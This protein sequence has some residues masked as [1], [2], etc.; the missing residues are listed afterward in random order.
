[1]SAPQ[2]DGIR[3]MV[4]VSDGAIAGEWHGNVLGTAGRIVLRT[5]PAHA[6]RSPPAEANSWSVPSLLFL[7]STAGYG[8]YH[9]GAGTY[10]FD[11]TDENRYRTGSRRSTTISLWPHRKKYLKS[12]TWT[13]TVASRNRSR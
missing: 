4:D 9:P 10:H 12:T 8:E 2:A 13:G 1:M 3:L 5:G 11:F 7:V 6:T